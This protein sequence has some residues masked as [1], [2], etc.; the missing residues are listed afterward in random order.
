MA[1]TKNSLR[2]SL[3]RGTS[4][5]VLGIAEKGMVCRR[6]DTNYSRY[7]ATCLNFVFQSLAARQPHFAIFFR[8]YGL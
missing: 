3:Y 7:I 8:T 6:I 5:L 1:I 2:D 4:V